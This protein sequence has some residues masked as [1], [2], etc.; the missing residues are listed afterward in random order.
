MTGDSIFQPAYN[1]ARSADDLILTQSAHVCGANGDFFQTDVYLTNATHSRDRDVSL[2]PNVLTGAP[3]LARSTRSRPAQTLEQLDV[4]VSEFG[5]ADPSVAGLRIHP[6]APP[7]LV[8]TNKR[9]FRSSAAPPASRS[10]PSRSRAAVGL[11]DGTAA[12]RPARPRPRREDSA[13][14]SGSP[15]SPARTPSCA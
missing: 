5:L 11:G 4:L 1:P 9:S 14:T 12:V 6:D 3:A 13:A 8:V 2:I 10:R 15:R 7:R